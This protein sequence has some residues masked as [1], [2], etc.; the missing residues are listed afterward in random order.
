MDQ[1]TTLRD[2]IADALDKAEAVETEVTPKNIEVSTETEEQ[3]ADRI[4]DEKGRFIKAEEPPEEKSAVEEKPVRKPPSSWKKDHWGQWD[5]LAS[6]PELA[7]LQDYIEQREAEFAKGVSAYKN[8]WDQAQ[9]IYEAIQPFVPELQQYGI[10]PAQWI[11]NLGNA[12]RTL[13]LGT[14]EQKLQMFAKLATDY[15]VPLQ[16]LTGQ[17][18]DPQ[19][20]NVLGEVNNLKTELNRIKQEREAQ[21]QAFIQQEIEKFKANAPYFEQVKPTMAQLLQ[22]GVAA[23]LKTAY[24]KAIRLH[25]DVWQEHQAQQAKAE[26]DERARQ[27]A[28]KKAKAVSTKSA[29]PTGPTGTVSGKKSLRDIIAEQVDE[30]TAQRL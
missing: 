13:A 24:D 14:P 3:K 21:E 25:D 26:A 23:D 11:Q 19:F 28:E 16:S 17:Q 1:Q 10:Q 30:V 4:R 8:Q 9:P 18:Q 7:T 6:D 27:A 20:P 12:H 2:S 15:G 29:T 22:S 5:R